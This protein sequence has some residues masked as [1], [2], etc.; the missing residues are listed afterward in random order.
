MYANLHTFIFTFTLIFLINKK[1]KDQTQPLPF[2]PKIK[3]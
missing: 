3:T 1:G 2:P